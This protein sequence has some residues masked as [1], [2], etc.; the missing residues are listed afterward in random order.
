MG[1]ITT[2]PEIGMIKLYGEQFH[3]CDQRP[4]VP[5]LQLSVLKRGMEQLYP[6]KAP[7]LIGHY[8][9]MLKTSFVSRIPSLFDII[10]LKDWPFTR[11]VFCCRSF[12]RSV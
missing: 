10:L 3:Y 4:R 2:N 9:S 5:M 1:S 8:L 6:A 12:Q 11:L 7:S